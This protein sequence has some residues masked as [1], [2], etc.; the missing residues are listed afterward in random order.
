[1][2]GRAKNTTVT[3]VAESKA[4]S[5]V[6][7]EKA[8]EGDGAPVLRKIRSEKTDLVNNIRLCLSEKG[9]KTNIFFA[10]EAASLLTPEQC[11]NYYDRIHSEEDFIKLSEKVRKRLIA[12][13]RPS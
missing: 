1:M 5:M 2:S 11:N 7:E 9:S 12:I 13:I 4:E 10:G 8:L 6:L 3:T